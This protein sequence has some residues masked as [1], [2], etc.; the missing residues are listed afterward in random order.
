MIYA[1]ALRR[2]VVAI[3]QFYQGDRCHA[4]FSCAFILAVI[5]LAAPIQH[6]EILEFPR[7][8]RLSE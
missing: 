7:G 2:V 6:S 3:G 4:L 5:L 1:V 8:L